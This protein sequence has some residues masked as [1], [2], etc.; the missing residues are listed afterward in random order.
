MSIEVRSR[1]A[2]NWALLGA[3]LALAACSSDGES[4][5]EPAGPSMGIVEVDPNRIPLGEA[6]R[7][8]QSGGSS[9]QGGSVN[10]GGSS[11]SGS[12]GSGSN[13][14]LE[15]IGKPC[16]TTADCAQ[17]LTCREDSDY[18]AHQQCTVSCADSETCEG[19]EA[20]SFCIG[21]N[22]CVHRCETNADCGPKTRCGTAGW[23]ERTGPGSGV[24]YCGGVATPCSLATDTSC[25]L[26][27]GCRDDSEC[28]GF[29]ESCYSQ[30]DSF[31]CNDLDGC[32]WSSSSNQCSGSAYSCSTFKLRTSCEF[33]PG[34]RWSA[35]CNGTA[36]SCDDTLAALCSNQPGC[37]LVT[38]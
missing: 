1:W 10:T 4:S 25:L 35:Q 2:L 33:Q 30:F 32:F 19:V 12:G 3:G 31:S 37:Q 21:A 7:P 27:S 23:C 38:D 15:R 36:R 11:G 8:A 34:C 17:G 16:E 14:P 20:G 9:G 29:A 18:I 24:P 26:S 13:K 28:T 6:G 5:S 22:V